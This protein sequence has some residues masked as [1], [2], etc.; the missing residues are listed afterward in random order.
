MSTKLPQNPRLA[1]LQ[2]LMLRDSLADA[3]SGHHVEQVEIVFAPGPARRRVPEAWLA[4]VS[5]TAALQRSFLTD[6]AK[7]SSAEF[8]VPATPL[9]LRDA[10]PESWDAWL[11]LDRTRSL[12]I[13][14]QVPWRASYWPEEGRFIWTFHHAL[15]DGRSI[16]KILSAFLMRIAGTEVAGPPLAHWQPP[17]PETIALAIDH[18]RKKFADVEPIQWTPTE[19]Y[20]DSGAAVR[21]LTQDAAT[22]LK[23]CANSA[24]VTIPTLLIWTWGQALM[25]HFKTTSVIV[26][27]LRAGEPQEGTA[28]FTMNTLPILI[29]LADPQNSS[30]QLLEFRD[31]LIAVRSIET[32]SAEDFPPPLFPNTQH[33][34][35]SVIMIE[36]GT[37][38]YLTG[39]LSKP[40]MVESLKLHEAPG[41]TLMATAHLLPDLQLTVEGPEKKSWLDRWVCELENLLTHEHH[42]CL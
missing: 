4:T 25:R 28:G 42:G 6:G 34:S 17:S 18:F 5:L 7:A 31:E 19:N 30:T 21:I 8:M 14:H 15:L 35:S 10:T 38:Q 16:T 32:V 9:T 33:I 12:L 2:R 3:T 11:A 36:R 24:R 27:Q 39:M 40:E 22:R 1:P 13:P 37:L 29:P 23:S 20:Q 41:E 26:E